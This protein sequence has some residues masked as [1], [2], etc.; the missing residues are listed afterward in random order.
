LFG[1]RQGRT[2][3]R[4]PRRPVSLSTRAPALLAHTPCRNSR[5]LFPWAAPPTQVLPLAPIAARARALDGCL[6][7]PAPPGRQQARMPGRGRAVRTAPGAP[8]LP[9]LAAWPRSWPHLQ[10]SPRQ[11]VS[12]LSKQVCMDAPAAGPLCATNKGVHYCIQLCGALPARDAH[13]GGSA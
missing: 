5:D 3:S 4:A 10:G 9:S 2:N 13:R 8:Q 6:G 12:N 7:S 11:A 1:G